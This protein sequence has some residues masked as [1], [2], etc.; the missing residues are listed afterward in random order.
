MGDGAAWI[1]GIADRHFPAAV[2][3][4]DWYHAVEYLHAAAKAVHP[5]NPPDAK[6]LSTDWTNK[7]WEGQFD[8]LMSSLR[9]QTEKLGTP[10]DNASAND[11]RQILRKTIGYFENH[12][13]QMN[14]V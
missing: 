8:P 6:I 3:I 1:D 12:R 2:R 9:E 14:W 7:L 4:V 10:P 13:Q 5:D 11:P